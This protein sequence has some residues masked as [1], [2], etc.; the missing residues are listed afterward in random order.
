MKKFFS[1]LLFLLLV[2]GLVACGDKTPTDETPDTEDVVAKVRDYLK[3]IAITYAEGDSAT[4]V[5][6]DVTLA[7]ITAEGVTVNWVSN[8]DA[9]KIEGLIGKVT[10]SADDVKV[11]LTVTV[12]YKDQ[13]LSKPFALT[14]KSTGPAIIDANEIQVSGKEEIEVGDEA[15]YTATVLPA[16]ASDKAFTWSTTNDAVATI[17]E[18]GKLTAVAVGDVKVVATLTSNN[19]VVGELAVKVNVKIDLTT[20]SNAINFDENTVAKVNAGVVGVYAQGYLLYDE[21]GYIL[22]YL[23][24]DATLDYKVGDYLTVTGAVTKYNGRNQFTATAKSE[25]LSEGHF[26]QVTASQFD[27]EAFAAFMLDV[28][29]AKLVNMV[30]TI[31]SVSDSYVNATID[32]IE[33]YGLSITYPVDKT[34]YEVGKQY[35]ITGY[36]LYSKEYNGVNSLYV[37]VTEFG[38]MHTITF[39]TGYEQTVEPIK[40]SDFRKVELPELLREEYIF[41]CWQENGVDVTEIT[42]NRD[43]NLTALMFQREYEVV[44]YETNG[45]EL[46][47]R[48]QIIVRDFNSF[49]GYI[50][51]YDSFTLY[52]K[53]STSKAWASVYYT[54][55]FL[56]E[57]EAGSNVFKVTYKAGS[58]S[59]IEDLLDGNT[60][61]YDYIL[62]SN[63]TNPLNSVLVDLTKEEHLYD[64]YFYLNVPADCPKDCYIKVIWDLEKAKAN[65]EVF[66]N[67]VDEEL[68]EAYKEHYT[69]VGWYDNPEFSGDMISFHEKGKTTYYAKYEAVEYK[70]EYELDGSTTTATLPEVYT[71]DT[72]DIILPTAEEMT[73]EDSKFLGWFDNAEAAG[74]AITKIAKGSFGDKKLYACWMETT[75]RD[76][77]LGENDVAVLNKIVPTIIVF[78]TAKQSAYKLVGT[79]LDAKY[80]DFEYV[81][82]T[83]FAS[84]E[85]A[86]LAAKENDV[87]YVMAGSYAAA[88][89]VKANNV[90]IIGPNYGVKGTGTR[91]D[92]ASIEGQFVVSATGVTVDGMKFAGKGNIM[93]KAG[94]FTVQNSYINGSCERIGSANRKGVITGSDAE[95]VDLTNIYITDNYVLVP[96]SSSGY[97]NQMLS[98]SKVTNL[99]ITGNYFKNDASAQGTAGTE[100][101]MIYNPCGEIVIAN[102]EFHILNEYAT[103]NFGFNGMNITTFDIIDNTFDNNGSG[104]CAGIVLKGINDGGVVNVIGNTFNVSTSA[105]DFTLRL[106][107]DGTY[108]CNGTLNVKYNGFLGSKAYKLYMAPT[109]PTDITTVINYENNYFNSIAEDD[110]SGAAASTKYDSQEALAA[111]YATYKEGQAAEPTEYKITYVLQGGETTAE[112]VNKYTKDSEDIVLPTAE[113]MSIE[114]GTF[115]GWYDNALGLGEAIAKIEKGSTGDKKLYA[116]W[117]VVVVQEIEL[118]ENDNAVITA[119]NPTI[120][121]KAGLEDPVYKINGVKYTVGD[122]LFANID[123]AIKSITAETEGDKF[124][125]YVLAG[126]YLMNNVTSAQ[127]LYANTTKEIILVGPNALKHG[128]GERVDEASIK[129]VTGFACYGKMEYVGLTLHGKDAKNKTD[130][131]TNYFETKGTNSELL[132]F[133]NCVI[134]DFRTFVYYN[135]ASETPANCVVNFYDCKFYQIGQFIIWTTANSIVK[136]VNFEGNYVDQKNNCQV[137]AATYSMIRI[138]SNSV[139]NVMNNIFDGDSPS[140]RGCLFEFSSATP[141]MVKFNTFKNCTARVIHS[142]S[143]GAAVFDQNLYLDGTGA[144]LAATPECIANSGAASATITVDATLASSE[145]DRATKYAAYKASQLA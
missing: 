2:L 112:L 29:F 106:N 118:T 71:I 145:E 135:D 123:N 67:E 136:E 17:D 111:G 4:S 76:L 70:I 141:A 8:N 102:H 119:Y 72:E 140:G 144:V 57:V 127:G 97:T 96:G 68:P 103:F 51:R 90:T 110:A 99:Y 49:D 39:N 132:E 50:N 134:Y 85:A 20:I 3:E 25:K 18:T 54:K 117:K 109:E 69:F 129:I 133:K 115:L 89:E 100:A 23:G 120:Y 15:T 45:G 58:G 16:D 98:F 79:G 116:C 83:V 44:T 65:L 62:S 101:S 92:E 93:L 47:F 114:D 12:Q 121:V 87:I 14:V 91:V 56:K 42:E 78:P 36:S 108:K 43:Y 104:A 55:I 125:I 37:M 94:N 80:A 139:L 10:R 81:N 60:Y 88:V 75:V 21:T 5:T 73:K 52:K 32:G 86:I 131:N 61:D 40:F 1:F 74:T 124:V 126:E 137:S 95:G 26:Y 9:I 143:T 33:G 63:A 41:V 35:E 22:Y 77:Q 53:G 34:A 142:S 130:A 82:G 28:P 128:N 31:T 113:A 59:S 48:N 19:E 107:F 122:K 46:M 24:K 138:R 66:K 6:Q 84:L 13:K 105:Y 64:Y 11:T 30:V 7:S 38:A 27:Q